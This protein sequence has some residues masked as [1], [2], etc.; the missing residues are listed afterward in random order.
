ME[1]NVI[2]ILVK[3][4]FLEIII[5]TCDPLISLSF[6]P[7][8]SQTVINP[9]HR[10]I[11]SITRAIGLIITQ[12]SGLFPSGDF[13]QEFLR[14]ARE[15]WMTFNTE[16]MNRVFGWIHYCQFLVTN[17]PSVQENYI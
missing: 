13:T 8:V 11:I 1:N 15:V 9:P 2:V 4:I 12:Q 16:A 3:V 6:L 5:I 14:N 10:G 17:G 7:Q